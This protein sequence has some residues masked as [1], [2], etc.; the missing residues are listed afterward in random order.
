[1]GRERRV[2]VSGRLLA[3]IARSLPN[4]PVDLTQ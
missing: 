1:M 2:L 3:D 4:K